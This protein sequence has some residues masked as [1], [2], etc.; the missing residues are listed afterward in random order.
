M[1]RLFFHI[2]FYFLCTSVFPGKGYSQQFF[3]R[4][5]NM[6]DGLPGT[7][8]YGVCEDR[9]GYLWVCGK[10]G[11]SRFD[12]RQF[13]AYGIMEGLPSL[14]TNTVFQD[15]QMRLWVSTPFGMVQFLNG[16]F[17]TFP[18][19]DKQTN[20]WVFKII[21]TKDKKIWAL[22]DK[23][24]YEFAK[25]E[26][27]KVPLYPGFENKNS[28]D[29]IETNGNLYVNYG[30]AIACRNENHQWQLIT[31]NQKYG[32]LFNKMARIGNEIWVS[33]FKN[34]FKISNNQLTPVFKKDFIP[35]GYYF[36]YAI[37]S[38][39]RL[40]LAGNGFLKVSKPRDWQH[41]TQVGN[42]YNYSSVY[43]DLSK[44]I[45]VGTSDGLI[46]LKEVPYTDIGSGSHD[47]P[48]GIYNIIALYNKGILISSGIKDG[49][50][51]YDQHGFTRIPRP[52][53]RTDKNYYEDPVDAYT[54]DGDRNLWL[55]TR[56]NKLL[57]FDGKMLT[58]YSKL[59]HLRPTGNVYDMEYVKSRN[60]FFICADSTLFVG[61]QTR[62]S[63]FNPRNTR[64]P[65]G[66]PTLIRLLQNGLLLLY[67]EGKGAYGIDSEDNLFSLNK[68]MRIDSISKGN[69]TGIFF[70][71][72][73]DEHFWIS[74][75]GLGLYEYGFTKNNK[76]FL[77][78]HF[79][80]NNGLQS[81]HVMS[82]TSD[83]QNRI[84]VASNMGIDILQITKNKNW[85]V[86]NFAK[87]E[88]LG[89]K[90]SAF[91]KLV[92]DRE[93]NVW[94]ST[95]DNIYHFATDSIRLK[96]ET[97]RVIIE[98]V[99]LAFKE[100]N[101]STIGDS[102]YSI[103]QL[104]W[105]PVLHY[106]QNSLGISFNAT[107]LSI[108]SSNPE[109]SYK[110][111]PLNT[112][113]STPSKSKY[114]SFAELAAGKY[115]FMVKAKDRASGWSTP[116]LF[117]FTIKP[118]F[119]NLWW[120]KLII[121]AL[122]AFIIIRLFMARIARVK[123]DAFVETQLKELEMKALKAQMNPHFVFNAIN[124][125][126][127]LIANDK[128][129]ESIHYIGAFSRLLR[130]VFDN[131]EKNL[132]SLDKEL[133]TVGLYIQLETLRL[134]MELHYNKN[135][136]DNVVAEFEKIP[137][138]LLQ[139]FVE[140]ALWHG[141]SFKEGRKEITITVSI[142][143]QWLLCD[144]IDNGIG[145]AKALELKEKSSVIHLSKGIEITRKRLSDFNENPIVTPF[146]FTDL[147]D[148]NKKSCGTMV[149]LHIKR[150][151]TAS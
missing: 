69:R 124:S 70:Y 89:V 42:Q 73:K 98:K 109:Y 60:K 12:G 133:E 142:D 148:E 131:S 74:F 127:A 2:L 31:S 36:D 8:I 50:M 35:N 96:K 21:E 68:E 20:P 138:L 44:N 45:W 83:G 55:A 57:R 122:T 101:W 63:V 38:K 47:N 18:T 137:P 112:T 17:V 64:L 145:R 58:D 11:I 92:R 59:L 72:D 111:L 93:G 121:I 75:P 61:D 80:V 90:Q 16:R 7:Q 81:N 113:W 106:N 134:N 85:E 87:A 13:V 84:W 143:D 25:G 22:T 79:D 5:Y 48:G 1:K 150:K 141:L 76:S 104:P 95:P 28:R 34:I 107:D 108:A 15:S 65:N 77:E 91:E 67:I 132:I 4:F 97:P 14:A 103:Y 56:Y 110:L 126:Q 23:G 62:I 151:T 6:N 88:E 140:N 33:T 105:Q 120:F 146:E 130:Q 115:Q 3:Y 102:L 9:N 149:S 54:Y 24:V 129:T 144:I 19:N 118:A 136:A 66:K 114:V 119:W 139:P 49:L 53:M 99:L 128:K 116:A 29:I 27:K 125:I 71:E 10:E 78:N 117:S 94:F 39:N 40:W 82:I 147:F 100:T 52:T 123:N 51:T 32:S 135:I 46:K 43:E 86:F 41:F 26:W 37:D 30:N